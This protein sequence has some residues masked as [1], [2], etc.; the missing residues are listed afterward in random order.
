[1]A[2]PGT[3][4]PPAATAAPKIASF[5]TPKKAEGQAQAE[6]A[7]A[8]GRFHSKRRADERAEES[9]KRRKLRPCARR[10]TRPESREARYNSE[11]HEF[12]AENVARRRGPDAGWCT[13]P[14]P[15]CTLTDP[16]M[17]TV[18]Q[19]LNTLCMAGSCISSP[20]SRTAV[21]TL[22]ARRFINSG[23]R[24]QL[25]TLWTELMTEFVCLRERRESITHSRHHRCCTSRTR[26]RT[27]MVAERSAAKGHNASLAGARGLGSSS[28]CERAAEVI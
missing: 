23:Y 26:P 20:C 3:P 24:N 27:I 8:A 1:M 19:S 4:D 17:C 5:R 11:M 6:Y 13:Q 12:V 2:A 10:F 7:E 28:S 14:P 18:E 9:R 21:C 25:K 16:P 22:R 15:P